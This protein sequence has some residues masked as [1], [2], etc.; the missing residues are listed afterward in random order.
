[1]EGKEAELTMKD[2]ELAIVREIVK[3]K[4]QAIQDMDAKYKVMC[5]NKEKRN[6]LLEET[7]LRHKEL[8]ASQGVVE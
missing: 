1:M 7:F 6:Q 2:R 3:E 5:D 4:E 8:V